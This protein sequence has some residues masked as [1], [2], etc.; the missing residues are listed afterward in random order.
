[1]YNI[2]ITN[3]LN[4]HIVIETFLDIQELNL[5]IVDSKYK[6]YS[7]LNYIGIKKDKYYILWNKN[8][9][10]CLNVFT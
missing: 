9:T 1:M 10:K 8:L 6:T 2:R 5:T 7:T 4:K 3:N